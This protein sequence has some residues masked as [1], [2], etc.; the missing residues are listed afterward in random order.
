MTEAF[1][2]V[3]VHTGNERKWQNELY[4]RKIHGKPHKKGD[5]VWLNTPLTSRISSWKLY[6]PWPGPFK[7]IKQV[8][9]STYRIQ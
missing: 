2:L 1:E 9:D 4:D 8:S 5:L 6:Y 7:V 3:G